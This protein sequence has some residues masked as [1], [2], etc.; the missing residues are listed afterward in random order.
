MIFVNNKWFDYINEKKKKLK[1]IIVFY[2]SLMRVS[3]IFSLHFCLIFAVIDPYDSG[4]NFSLK[5]IIVLSFWIGTIGVIPRSSTASNFRFRFCCC[6]WIHRSLLIVI[7]NSGM[8]LPEVS[9]KS[10]LILAIGE[11]YNAEWSLIDLC[12]ALFLR[13]TDLLTDL[14]A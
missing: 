1:Q 5:W 12:F 7:C 13:K 3:L 10:D 2:I 14:I 9:G 6:F 4:M 11:W 8:S